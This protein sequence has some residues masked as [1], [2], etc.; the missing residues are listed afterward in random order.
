MFYLYD[1]DKDGIPELIIISDDGKWENSSCDVFAYS[2]NAAR[3]IGSLNWDWFGLIG[4]PNDIT[5]G[6]YSDDSYKGHYGSLYYYNIQNGVLFEQLICEYH[7]QP[8]AG[9]EGYIRIYGEDGSIQSIVED[10][11]TEYAE[12][13]TK[14]RTLFNWTWFDFYSITE[15]NISDVIIGFDFLK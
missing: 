7:F 1:I 2:N 8:N 3:H 10:S 6:L 11:D 12:D 5:V 9:R 4:A 15:K 14:A 13:S